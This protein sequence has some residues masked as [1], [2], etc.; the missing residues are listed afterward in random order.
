[1]TTAA[2]TTVTK[3]M[4]TL[5]EPTQNQIVDHIRDY[6][7]EIQ[8]EKKWDTTFQ[9]SQASLIRAARRAKQEIAAGLSEPMDYSRL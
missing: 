7:A 4:E 1:M 3:M 6:L 8:D 5:P 9:N 2:I